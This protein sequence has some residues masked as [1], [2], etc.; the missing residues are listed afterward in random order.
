M[1][2]GNKFICAEITEAVGQ[3]NALTLQKSDICFSSLIGIQLLMKSI[4]YRKIKPGC[5]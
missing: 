4:K 5:L 2:W 1:R 3:V